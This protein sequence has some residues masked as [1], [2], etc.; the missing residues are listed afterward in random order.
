MT[1]DITRLLVRI[2]PPDGRQSLWTLHAER[3]LSDSKVLR[4][5]QLQPLSPPARPQLTCGGVTIGVI[6]LLSHRSS[7]DHPYDVLERR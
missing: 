6:N 3:V 1:R 7:A 4:P 2:V 5:S